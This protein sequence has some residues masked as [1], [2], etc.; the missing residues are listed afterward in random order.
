MDIMKL[1]AAAATSLALTACGGG[2]EPQSGASESEVGG[3]G[4]QGPSAP[5]MADIKYTKYYLKC[6]TPLGN[7]QEWLTLSRRLHEVDN[8]PLE[9]TEAGWQLKTT[10]FVYTFNLDLALVR[11]EYQHGSTWWRVCEASEDPFPLTP[12]VEPEPDPAPTIEPVEPEPEPEPEPK[13]EPEPQPVVFRDMAQTY[14]VLQCQSMA[15][16]STAIAQVL[17]DAGA[18]IF[19]GYQEDIDPDREMVV[20]ETGWSVGYQFP[21][22]PRG[23]GGV[24]YYFNSLGVLVGY[25]LSSTNNWMRCGVT[26]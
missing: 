24:E 1:L 11:Y 3:A 19:D 15:G 20:T 5:V 17:P 22:S 18:I 16:S 25:S 13:P 6:A 26:E 9:R 12:V 2:G 23:G 7:G 10:R 8:R 4:G 21:S 14:D